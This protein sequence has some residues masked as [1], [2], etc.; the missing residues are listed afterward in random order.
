MIIGEEKTCR[1]RNR[2]KIIVMLEE[3]EKNLL[4]K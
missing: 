2:D 3:A 4:V 1:E